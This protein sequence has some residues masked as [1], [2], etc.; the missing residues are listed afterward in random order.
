M[1][2]YYMATRRT[3]LAA[4]A[5]AAVLSA[6][7]A[8]RGQAG[9]LPLAP[10][11]LDEAWELALARS[12]GPPQVVA[13]AGLSV[14][15]ADGY[16]EVRASANGFHCLVERSF[17]A[18]TDNPAD[19]WDPRVLAPICFAPDAV[20]TVMQ[21]ELLLARLVAGGGTQRA[22]RTAVD[23]AY[24]DGTLR[25]P[26]TAVIAYM[27]SSG[28]WLGPNITHW[29]PH[30][31]VWAPGLEAGDVAPADVGSFGL[32]SGLPVI[33]TRFGPRQPLIVIPVATAIDPERPAPQQ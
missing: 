24:A 33:D 15:R 17:T 9:D 11:L 16:H 25:Y 4:A 3:F 13:G 30:V 27:F 20:A 6:P 1:A 18:P 5:V 32:H 29:H 10:Y 8:L 21:R 2:K 23:A 28:Q 31:M 19:F 7:A 26:E 14:L 12:A 22:I